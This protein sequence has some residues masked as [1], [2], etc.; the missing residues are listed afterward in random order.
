[1]EASQEYPG[2]IVEKVDNPI[3]ASRGGRITADLPETS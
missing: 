1:M 3:D 2:F